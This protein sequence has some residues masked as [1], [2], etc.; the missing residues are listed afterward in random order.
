MR[1]HP[2]KNCGG[3]PKKTKLPSENA[4]TLLYGI[5]TN[6][7]SANRLSK[8][9]YGLAQ[10]TTGMERVA[11]HRMLSAITVNYS[12]VLFHQFSPSNT[13][14][15]PMHHSLLACIFFAS[16]QF[17]NSNLELKFSLSQGIK[18]SC[19]LEYQL[20]RSIFVKYNST[21]A[22]DLNITVNTGRQQMQ[23]VC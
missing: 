21:L 15:F 23:I 18:P 2:E 22:R 8:Q 13:H 11:L 4:I 5:F 3:T 10:L 12:H 14:F 1:W 16:H 20:F 17:R 9:P 19:I 6:N 7:Q